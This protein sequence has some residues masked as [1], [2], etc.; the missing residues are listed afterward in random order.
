MLRDG[1]TYI[2]MGQFTDAGSI[3]TNWHR[4]CSKDITIVGSWGFTGNDIPLGIDLLHRAAARY[5]WSLVQSEYPLSESGIA[6]AV[7]DAM[8]MRCLKATIRPG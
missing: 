7:A 6:A 8:A 4:I 2:E 5:P 3:A 1:G